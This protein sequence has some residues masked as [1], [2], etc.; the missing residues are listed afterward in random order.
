[1]SK[2]GFIA[3]EGFFVGVGGAT[4]NGL[5]G[6][7]IK[8]SDSIVTPHKALSG[9]VSS[10][11][12]RFMSVEVDGAPLPRFTNLYSNYWTSNGAKT[13]KTLATLTAIY[14]GA[15]FKVTIKP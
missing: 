4:S 10:G 13:G 6:I 15:D 14:L 12:F 3:D 11:A 8:G 5:G 7:M 1:V 2:K 9:P